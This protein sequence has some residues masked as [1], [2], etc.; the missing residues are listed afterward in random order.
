[1]L[2]VKT[3]VEYDTRVCVY[4]KNMLIQEQIV[5]EQKPII[6]LEVYML[7]TAYQL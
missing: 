6:H 1:M 5:I 4:C 3:H 2:V 7:I